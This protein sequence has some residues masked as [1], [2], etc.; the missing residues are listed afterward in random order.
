MLINIF[1]FQTQQNQSSLG[2]LLNS[3]YEIKNALVNSD[4]PAAAVKAGQFIKVNNSLEL[5]ALPD[6]KQNA[7]VAIQ[8][9]LIADAARISKCKRP[10][11]T[12]RVFCCLLPGILFA[13]ANSE[14][15]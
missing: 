12:A 11:Q 10:G 1:S 9:N 6:G 13:G 2:S 3:Y 15:V 4:A 8:K 7:F 5:K 14:V